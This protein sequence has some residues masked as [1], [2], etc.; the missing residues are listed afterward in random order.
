MEGGE[1]EER[2]VEE[3]QERKQLLDTLVQEVVGVYAIC[4]LVNV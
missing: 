4:M 1:D 3:I 2:V